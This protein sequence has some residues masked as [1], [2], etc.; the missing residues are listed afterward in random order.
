MK[1]WQTSEIG[2][3]TQEYYATNKKLQTQGISD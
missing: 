2:E 3:K 1:C